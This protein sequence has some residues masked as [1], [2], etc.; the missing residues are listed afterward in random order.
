MSKHR[1]DRLRSVLQRTGTE[2]LLVTSALNRKYMTGFTGT[3]GFALVTARGDAV[4][5][6]DFRYRTQAP[7]QSPDYRFA[8][9]DQ[10]KPYLTLHE[11]LRELGIRRLGFEQQHVTVGA[12]AAMN[13]EL[14]GIELVATDGLVESLRMI[15][16]EGELAVIREACK[17][18]DDTFS[19]V[20]PMLKPG[21]SE[22]DIALE[23]ELFMRRRG[24]SGTS[25]ETIVAS[26]VRSSMPHGVASDKRLGAGELVTLDF[27]ALYNGYCSDLTRTVYLGGGDSAALAR[28]K[29]I[30]DIV[31]EAQLAALAVLK[32][33]MT[34]AEGDKAARDV[35]E[36][37]GYGAMFGHGTGHSF[38]MEIHE[39]PRLNRTGAVVLEPG[40]V[41]TVEPGIYLP[42]FGG[43]RIEDD[44]VLVE[45]GIEVL[46]HSSKAFTILE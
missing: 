31:L 4:L 26:G 46:T 30:Y 10:M 5:L 21:V 12:H 43:V 39:S 41:V 17:L 14:E 7:E 18:A 36:R 1:L 19:H 42:E 37:Y 27:G 8:E 24:A 22:R 9:T 25:F 40:M 11:V 2:A 16:D 13:R 35:I 34:G 20:L 44:V 28:A 32:P 33:G 23:I 6:S 38:G 3:S 15:K 45:G 29:E